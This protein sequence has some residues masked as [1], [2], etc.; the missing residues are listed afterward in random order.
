MLGTIPEDCREC[1]DCTSIFA[2]GGKVDSDGTADAAVPYRRTFAD[3]LKADGADDPDNCC[4]LASS[5]GRCGGS[6]A[7]TGA[8]Y[9]AG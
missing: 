3:G 4:R 1:A 6:C 8:G 7:E 9:C 2:S 5:A